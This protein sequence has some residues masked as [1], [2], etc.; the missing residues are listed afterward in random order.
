VHRIV[1]G[2]RSTG[3]R[4]LKK[5]RA[6]NRW[7]ELTIQATK[8]KVAHAIRDAVS[9]SALRKS[10]EDTKPA[11]VARPQKRSRLSSGEDVAAASSTSV[12]AVATAAYPTVLTSQ[13]Q[14]GGGPTQQFYSSLEA[15]TRSMFPHPSIAPPQVAPTIPHSA[16][17]SVTSQ[18]AGGSDARAHSPI[19]FHGQS[20]VAANS[21]LPGIM[22][23]AAAAHFPVVPPQPQRQLSTTPQQRYLDCTTGGFQMQQHPS[24]LGIPTMQS[25]P[26]TFSFRQQQ[27]EQTFAGED[28][29][30]HNPFLPEETAA[31]LHRLM[32]LP[33]MATAAHGV[34]AQLPIITSSTG[35][36]AAPQFYHQDLRVATSG[37]MQPPPMHHQHQQQQQH[38]P[39][40]QA[41]HQQQQQHRIAPAA[42]GAV[43]V[44]AQYAG[45]PPVGQDPGSYDSFIEEIESVLGPLPPGHEDA[46][47]SLLKSQQRQHPPR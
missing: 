16:T 27:S 47:D 41:P 26:S 34:P 46:M 15:T 7:D 30:R 43:P 45:Q 11:A 17:T 42:A 24:T 6:T 44:A 14:G 29:N 1:E 22:R 4:F 19:P 40:H 36:P 8:D 18:P 33:E 31:A 21:L 9:A 39:S 32:S 35:L 38:P 28:A 13:Q 25:I 3:G 5:D 20:A 2:I 23:Q 37:L 10:K 12:A